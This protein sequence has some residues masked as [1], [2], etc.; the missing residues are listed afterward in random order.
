MF[1]VFAKLE[2]LEL[3]DETCSVD[4]VTLKL[5]N[6]RGVVNIGFADEAPVCKTEVKKGKSK[7]PGVPEASITF[8]VQGLSTNRELPISISRNNPIIVSGKDPFRLVFRRMLCPLPGFDDGATSNSVKPNSLIPIPLMR[9]GLFDS[10]FCYR[11]GQ[12][13]YKQPIHPGMKGDKS[14]PS[15]MTFPGAR[16]FESQVNLYYY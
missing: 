8:T 14:G 13:C 6:Y 11:S 12:D 7:I 4:H 1:G 10:E 9:N 16:C 15:T 2:I 5:F 3:D